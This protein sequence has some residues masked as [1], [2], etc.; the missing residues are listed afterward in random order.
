MGVKGKLKADGCGSRNIFYL[1]DCLYSL[2]ALSVVSGPPL[3][4]TIPV[5][6]KLLPP[7]WVQQ[8]SSRNNQHT[9]RQNCQVSHIF[10]FFSR[11][12]ESSV[13]TRTGHRTL[14]V[15][16]FC[17]TEFLK[18]TNSVI[19]SWK[20]LSVFQKILATQSKVNNKE[21]SPTIKLP[22]HQSSS[23]KTS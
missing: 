17:I 11:C 19:L 18:D 20:L 13:L 7:T 14:P 1:R 5:V 8:W 9:S 6:S 10:Y 12:Y 15:L 3:A 22:E 23:M 4:Y 21:Q 2:H 16:L